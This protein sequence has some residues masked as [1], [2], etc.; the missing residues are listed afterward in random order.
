MHFISRF[1]LWLG[2]LDQRWVIWGLALM[3]CAW[4]VNA[5]LAKDSASGLSNTTYDVMVKKR[6]WAQ[7]LDPRV[8]IVDIDEASL[9]AMS[10]EFGR[11]PWPRD[12]L[13]TVLDYLERQQPASITWDIL[14]S[15][16]D[17]LSPGGDKAFDE[18]VRRSAHSVFPIVRL[19]AVYDK[20]SHLTRTLLPQLWLSEGQK[21]ITPSTVAMI[22]PALPAVAASRL[23]FN[24]GYP[25]EDGVIRRYP[26]SQVLPDQS[27][28][29]SL[30]LNTA[31]LVKSDTAF[32]V[33]NLKP[34]MQWRSERNA[35]P[36]VP[37]H[38]LF[39]A[40]EGDAK[41]QAIMANLF[42]KSV[43]IIGATASSL[44]DVHTSPLGRQHAGV[45]ILA[46]A[47]D[48]AVNG[49]QLAELPANAIAALTVFLCLLIAGWVQFKGSQ[50]LHGGLV[51]LP[52]A[53][54]F[55]SFASLHG[56]PFFLDLSAA[57]ATL[58]AY[59]AALKTWLSWRRN[60]WCEYNPKASAVMAIYAPVNAQAFE[61]S[62]MDWLILVLQKSAPAARII[63]GDANAA[64]PA[65]L[66]WAETLS[67]IA[68]AGD[69]ASLLEL[70]D[71]L[72]TKNLAQ[73]TV[74]SPLNMLSSRATQA[75]QAMRVLA[76]TT[77][78]VPAFIHSGQL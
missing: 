22:P 35:Y 43:I 14:F 17:R 72:S 63:G 54:L 33:S 32:E 69:E 48:N 23:G 2:K 8:V 20:D 31:R 13:A 9:L 7:P 66:R 34:L 19:P 15:D 64:W 77:S 4:Q 49:H 30:A 44:H 56:L 57:A 28:I 10:K 70:S 78:P 37:F 41:Q 68:V 38:A 76:L 53:L 5:W 74:I 16:A 58:L 45:D 39:A 26:W 51:L 75:Q 12:T 60:Y 71:Y 47:I 50:V 59:V 52:T 3:V 24:N 55:L 21:S 65:K 6:L 61:E 18:A 29:Q 1:T 40:A 67:A 25:D 11:W 36:R 62:G 27:R 42:K 46:T 73:T